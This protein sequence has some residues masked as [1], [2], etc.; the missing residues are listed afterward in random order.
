MMAN[1]SATNATAMGSA[2]N[3]TAMGSA[4]NA[5]AMTLDRLLA[6]PVT[7]MLRVLLV[8]LVGML[9]ARFPRRPQP[10]LHESARRDVGGLMINLAWPAMALATVGKTISP[11]TLNEA[12]PVAVW[13]MAHIA[14][15][16]VVCGAIARVTRVQADFR[17]AFTVA[18]S[19][20]NSAALP[21]LVMET[22]CEQPQLVS[23]LPNKEECVSTSFGYIM[24]YTAVWSLFMF[25]FAVPYLQAS[26]Q[27]HHVKARG[28]AAKRPA[29]VSAIADEVELRVVSTGLELA[30]DEKRTAGEDPEQEVD[31]ADHRAVAT[32]PSKPEE[33]E[34]GGVA[35]HEVKAVS[36]WTHVRGALLSPPIVATVI[37]II[38]G[39]ITPLSDALFRGQG[40]AR[41]L[42]GT[43]ET[44][45]QPGVA[46]STMVM[47]AALLP[48]VA[49]AAAGT[50]E[51]TKANDKAAAKQSCLSRGPVALPTV[52]LLCLL[53]LAVIPASGFGI[54]YA[55][56]NAGA[57]SSTGRSRLVNFVILIEFA[58]PSAQTCVVVLAKLGMHAM[59]RQLAFAYIF[60]YA[61]SVFTLTGFTALAL[62]LLQSSTTGGV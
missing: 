34:E 45:A 26:H 30:V 32:V 22:L 15:G 11:D 29:A 9:A 42:G 19:F 16:A 59:A 43:F 49:R 56:Q 51:V 23:D 3:A 46:L 6:V 4:T 20:V 1:G 44:I 36:Y 48:D 14:L 60:E 41:A 54:F 2:T 39:M 47:A 52:A 27:K 58:S 18:G 12:W 10:L 8:G 50:G 28:G 37:G 7:A 21:M 5:T 53:R 38:V 35:D 55:L 25:L 62:Y 17:P 13:A 61:A 40:V 33:G 24:T 57:V 31:G